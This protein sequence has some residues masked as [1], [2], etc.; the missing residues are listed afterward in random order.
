MRRYGHEQF[1][2]RGLRNV[3]HVV[4]LAVIASNLLQHASTLT[5]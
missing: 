2:V 4:L 1:L 3:T 5:G